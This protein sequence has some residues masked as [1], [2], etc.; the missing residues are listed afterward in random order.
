[1]PQL[2][3][4][5]VNRA[6]AAMPSLAASSRIPVRV[7]DSVVP[8]AASRPSVKTA[9]DIATLFSAMSISK[10]TVVKPTSASPST[11]HALKSKLPIAASTSASKDCP[12]LRQ[13]QQR[14]L[15]KIAPL[16]NSASVSERIAERRQRVIANLAPGPKRSTPPVKITPASTIKSSSTSSRVPSLLPVTTAPAS[17]SQPSSMPS[18]VIVPA[19]AIPVAVPAPRRYGWLTVQMPDN[20]RQDKPGECNHIYALVQISDR[21]FDAESLIPSAPTGRKARVQLLG[22]FKPANIPL[23]RT[24]IPHSISPV[25]LPHT[26][27]QFPRHFSPVYLPRRLKSYK[28]RGTSDYCPARPS[29]PGPRRNCGYGPLYKGRTCDC[30][31]KDGDVPVR[32]YNIPPYQWA[33]TPAESGV[34]P[35]PR[36]SRTDRPRK[37]VQFAED[38]IHTFAGARDPNAS[39]IW[40]GTSKDTA[41]RERDFPEGFPLYEGGRRRQFLRR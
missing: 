29:K 38:L 37:V 2:I 30:C 36:K 19:A 35:H 5:S 13:H 12:P 23:T 31:E 15:A 26:M 11:S 22:R 18:D 14:S 7:N 24:P 32:N 3:S 34:D 40:E 41:T 21:I 16:A 17:T 25:F 9:G 4:L 20:F 6:S 33:T 8:A 1:M 27:S 39:F 28:I 10:P